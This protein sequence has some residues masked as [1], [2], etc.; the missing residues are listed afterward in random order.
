MKTK[1]K[2]LILGLALALFGINASAQNGLTSIQVEKYYVSNAADSAGSV[3]VLPVGSVTY[4]IFAVML[5]GY[6]FELAFG[7]TKNPLKLTT[8]TAFF[9]NEDRGATTPNGISSAFLKNNTV[10]L[11]SWLSVGGTATG[12]VGIPKSE[13]NG[14]ANLIAANTILKNNDASAGI[15]LTTQDGMIAGTIQAVT[16]LG[17]NGADSVF[18]A[19]SNVGNSFILTNGGWSSLSGSTGIT[20]SNKVLIGQFTTNGVFHYELNIQIGTPSGG[21]ESY[22]NGSPASGEIFIPSLVGTL[23]AVNT[24]PTVSITSPTN[25]SSFLTGSVIAIN[26]TAADADGSVTQVEFFVDG[27]SQGVKTAAPYTVNYTGTAGTHVLTAKATD[28]SGAVTTSTAVN[29]NV[30]NNLPPTVSITAPANG[31]NYLVGDVVTIDATAADADGTVT[32]VEFFVD[33][34]SIGIKTTAPYSA[35]YTAVLGSHALTAKATDNQGAVTT[36]S[37]VNINVLNN[38][39]PTVSITAPANGS[40]FTAP[41]VVHI[42]VTAAD[43]DGT[44]AQV[45]FFVNGVSIGVVTTAPYQVNWTSVIGTANLTAKATDNKGAVTTSAVVTI[46]IANPNALPYSLGTIV[47]TCASNGFCLPL[48]AVDSVKNVIGYDIT[49]QYNKTKVTPTGVVTVS[50]SLINSSYVTTTNN[51]DTAHSQIYISAFLNTSAP[52]NASFN[53][54]GELLCVGFNKTAAF[55]SVDTVTFSVSSLEESYYSG[56][57]SKL[58]T[59]GKYITYK[60]TGFVGS[61]RFWS[62]DEPIKYDVANPNTYLITNIYGNNTSCSSKSATAV[63]PDLSGNFHY[64]ISNGLDVD[65]V[66]DILPTTDVQPVINGF[67]ALLGGK[68]LVN[69]PSFVPSVYQI[70]ALDVNLDGVISAGDISQI[71][72]RSVLMI[73]EFKQAWNYNNS[74]VSNGQLSKDWLFADSI[75]ASTNAAYKISTTYPANDGSGY[76]KYRVPAVPFC[77]PVP[78]TNPTDCPVIGHETYDG[79]LLG[80]V[81][82]SYAGIAPDGHLKAAQKILSPSDKVVFDMADASIHGNTIDIPVYVSSVDVTNSLDFALKFNESVLSFDSV[83]NNTTYLQPLSYLNPNDQTLRVT[84]NST[85]N[86]SM[87]TPLVSLRFK[88]LSGSVNKTD[89]NSLRAYINGDST[90]T[91]VTDLATGI[92]T[93]ASV[94]MVSVYPNPTNKTIHVEVSEKSTVQLFD[95]SGKEVIDARNVNANEKQAIDVLSVANGV[96]FLKVSN[97]KFITVKKVVI[98]K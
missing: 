73:P 79:I 56:T 36:S 14:V 26:A 46:N 19:T 25:G 54:I 89:L 77:L 47:N 62:D 41:A 75:Q 12:Q 43:V 82:G 86:Y 69:D 68:V 21:T 15:P 64:S 4:R 67:D 58:V 13:D 80:D 94:E 74:G 52:A 17:L 35:T 78:V 28:N 7:N 71:N 31:A 8:S 84:S 22:V 81:N 93:P 10:A 97:D 85:Q 90:G 11:D 51:I 98:N 6:K 55:H 20:A 9:N 72:Q 76:S 53:G 2:T 45:E 1:F 50:N 44:V 60:D 40:S 37:I 83:I 95:I 91:L 33:G 32:Q 27:V 34:T 42:T 5:P 96:Y 39:P 66:R 16:T 18:N 38:T 24:P 92:L 87:N 49:L 57:A 63:Q 30:A 23:G 65:I 48:I 29:I 70:I 61:L 59:T 88:T 3:G